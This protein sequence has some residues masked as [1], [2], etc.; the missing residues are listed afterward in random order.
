MEASLAQDVLLT[1]LVRVFDGSAAPPTPIPR[2]RRIGR[3]IGPGAVKW[4]PLLLVGASVGLTAAAILTAAPAILLA[5]VCV[6]VA[7]LLVAATLAY[8]RYRTR[9]PSTPHAPHTWTHPTPQPP[10]TP[11]R[12]RED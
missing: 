11:T 2:Y 5:A 3:R 6:S 9:H 7:T 10:D 8:R 4:S 1:E 12:R